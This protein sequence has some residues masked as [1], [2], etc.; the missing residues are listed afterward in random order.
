M[1]STFQLLILFTFWIKAPDTEVTP[2]SLWPR[3]ALFQPCLGSQLKSLI[4]NMWTLLWLPCLLSMIHY[5][6]GEVSVS[7]SPAVL[8]TMANESVTLWCTASEYIDDDMGLSSPVISMMPPS[9]EELSSS[10]HATL[11][12]LV[13]Q[14]YPDSV[15]VSW[16]VDGS[17]P[18]VKQ[19]DSQSVRS[20]DGTYSM[21]SSLTLPRSAWE[22]G[23]VFACAVAHSSLQSPA[24]QSIRRSHKIVAFKTISL[25]LPPSSVV[26][27]AVEVGLRAVVGGLSLGMATEATAAVEGLLLRERGPLVAAAVRAAR[28]VGPAGVGAVLCCAGLAVAFLSMAAGVALG[29]GVM[30]L[31]AEAGWR[32]P[33]R[34]PPPLS[35]GPWLRGQASG[36]Q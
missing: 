32:P 2:T 36:Q 31:T 7:Q 24:T 28:L 30:T 35:P 34:P 8:S 17:A 26:R 12:C 22:S 29:A 18:N 6:D 19:Q 9:S 15:S 13:N 5:C 16:T 4:L 10:K 21:S 23:E 14:F 25:S 3:P 1:I 33:E 20:S 27:A 11:L